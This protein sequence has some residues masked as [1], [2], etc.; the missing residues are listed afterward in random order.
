[1][2][3]RVFRRRAMRLR[4][5]RAMSETVRKRGIAERLNHQP[6]RLFGSLCDGGRYGH[7]RSAFDGWPAAGGNGGDRAGGTGGGGAV[8]RS[9]GG[10]G[11]VFGGM[12]RTRRGR[13]GSRGWSTRARSDSGRSN[14]CVVWTGWR[15]SSGSVRWGEGRSGRRSAAGGFWRRREPIGRMGTMWMRISC[16]HRT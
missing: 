9:R 4:A 11:R 1:M 2:R 3:G 14:R 15:Q 8:R 5:G 12:C 6:G 16:F 13:Y 7:P 10:G